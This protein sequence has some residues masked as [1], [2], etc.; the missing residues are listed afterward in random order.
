MDD[1]WLTGRLASRQEASI[2]RWLHRPPHQGRL[3]SLDSGLDGRRLET[4]RIDSVCR[5]MRGLNVGRH[6]AGYSM[7]RA[8]RL[9]LGIKPRSRLH[10]MVGSL[11]MG[12]NRAAWHWNGGG[13]LR[14]EGSRAAFHKRSPMAHFR[15]YSM[16]SCFDVGCNWTSVR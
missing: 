5:A 6:P 2:L 15:L 13:N 12:C 11:H 10:G 8:L 7:V 3:H 1:G 9:T 16:M 14:L 4:R